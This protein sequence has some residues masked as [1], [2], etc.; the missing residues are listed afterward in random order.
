MGL[1]RN[2]EGVLDAGAIAA[3]ER[4]LA[5]LADPGA[6]TAAEPAGGDALG[7]CPTML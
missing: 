6:S 1:R 2:W 4:P 7:L 3:G 5:G